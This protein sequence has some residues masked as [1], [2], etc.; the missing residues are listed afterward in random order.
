MSLRADDAHKRMNQRCWLIVVGVLLPMQTLLT[1]WL[2]CRD[3]PTS[4]EMA[5]MAAGVRILHQRDFGLYTVNPPLPKLLAVLPLLAEDVQVSWRQYD[6]NPALRREWNVGQ[7][8]MWVNGTRSLWLYTV[9]RWTCI[10]W[11]WLGLMVCYLWAK[12]LYGPLAGVAAAMMWTFSPAI[13]ANS[14]LITP[15]IP[16]AAMAVTILYRF[17]QYLAA[18]DWR[19]AI[20][21]GIVLG[22]GELTKMTLLLLYPL[23]AVLMAIAVLKPGRDVAKQIG[24]FFLCVLVSVIVLNA[25]YLFEGT[26][27]TLGSSNFYSESLGGP[28]DDW[29]TPGNRF[30]GTA[31]GTLPVPLPM[32]Y[33]TGIDL[34]KRDFEGHWRPMYSYLRGH[35]QLGGW[36][37]YYLYCLLVKVPVGTWLIAI[38]FLATL[39]CQRDE[40]AENRHEALLLWLAPIALFAF[41]SSQTGFSRYYR[42]VLPCA[43]FVLIGLSRIFA[44]SWSQPRR[45]WI[46]I[47]SAGLV[48]LIIESLAVYP[49]SLG[50]VN[51]VA[52]GPRAGHWHLLDSNVDW[53]QDLYHLR[54]W[55]N[56]HPGRRPLFLAYSGVFDP[57]VMGIEAPRPPEQRDGQVPPLPMGWY[58]V[59]V[60]HLH[61]YDDPAGPFTYFQS[62]TPQDRAGYSILIYHVAE[63]TP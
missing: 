34:Q 55:M 57:R 8:F 56:Q 36:W 62:R 28:R 45:W 31:L 1:V 41:V 19:G 54:D 14:A 60:N 23:L 11:T 40:V 51:V 53:G 18:P 7:D 26:G 38:A 63:M 9:A 50:F 33:L 49:H 16:A 25:G 61:G 21:T 3:S 13:L 6:A 42:Y 44:T 2:A 37:Y 32:A 22:I 29:D 58:A 20:I 12:D 4:D 27:A 24:Q 47:G 39:R 10:P 52:G 48:C 35:Q 46:R 15:D 30:R 43:P 17:R 5:H 59:S